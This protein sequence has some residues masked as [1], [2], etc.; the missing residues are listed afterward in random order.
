MSITMNKVQSAITN[1]IAVEKSS[2]KLIG[3]NKKR[4]TISG[5]LPDPKWPNPNMSCNNS[6]TQDPPTHPPPTTPAKQQTAL[7]IE[8]KELSEEDK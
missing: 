6:K 8:D 4:K 5:E 3:T 1:Y 2:D 7:E